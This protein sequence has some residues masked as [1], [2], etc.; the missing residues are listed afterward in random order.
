MDNK[1][2][3]SAGLGAMLAGIVIGEGL[4]NHPLPP[5]RRKSG[6]SRSEALRKEKTR[7]KKEAKRMRR[8]NRIHG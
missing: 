2:K 7:K 5:K 4:L 3:I 6:V 1:N 8:M